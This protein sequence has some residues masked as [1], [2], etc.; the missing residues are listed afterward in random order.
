MAG[1]RLE[2]LTKLFAS[3][4]AVD[5]IDLTVPDGEFVVLVGPSGCGK[6]T[7]LN[8]IAGLETPTAGDIFIG[9]ARVTDWEP[10][11]RNLGMVFQSLALFPHLSVF[12]N[13]AFPLRIKKVPEAEVRARVQAVAATT[14]IAPLLAK[15][16]ATLSGGEAQRVALA[17]TIIVKPAVFLMDEPLSSLDAKLR[18]EMRTELKRL[19]AQLSATF[20]YVTHDQAEAMTMADRIVVMHQGKIQQVGP[21]LQIY[22]DPVNRFVAGRCHERR[23]AG[24]PRS[25][26]VPST[27]A[28]AMAPTLHPRR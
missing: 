17:R 15:R 2:G 18:V 16:P 9:D 26:S 10:R 4:R 20:I 13:I 5:A 6:T 1:V 23:P 25:A 27:C 14:R 19:H 24:R 11:D 21:P 12:D 8:M 28:S 3:T 7:T 22:A